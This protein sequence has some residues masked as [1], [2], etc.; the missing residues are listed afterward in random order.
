MNFKLRNI[1]WSTQHIFNVWFRNSNG[2]IDT[3]R[4]HFIRT[5][6]KGQLWGSTA[7]AS[8]VDQ[9]DWVEIANVKPA[10]AG[11]GKVLVSLA[12]ALLR[13]ANIRVRVL[14]CH[15]IFEVEFVAFQALKLVLIVDYKV[16][17]TTE[18]NVPLFH[19]NFFV[20]FV[21]ELVVVDDECRHA[22]EQQSKVAMEE[23]K[24]LD[25]V[26]LGDTLVPFEHALTFVDGNHELR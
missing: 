15:L 22:N 1:R 19:N 24:E 3:N 11:S 5:G 23:V 18:H 26:Y 4:S 10:V 12:F 21:S 16:A 8:A 7:S 17:R 14:P 25:W 20:C 13:V 2:V 6:I 9:I